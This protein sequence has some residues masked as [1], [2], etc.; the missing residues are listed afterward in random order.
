M[1]IVKFFCDSGA[2]VHSCRE[3]EI[4]TVEDLGLAVNEWENLS[5]DAKFE[6]VQEWAHDKLEIGY[7]KE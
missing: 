6:I 2:N 1:A 7:M 4:N 5:E 3:E